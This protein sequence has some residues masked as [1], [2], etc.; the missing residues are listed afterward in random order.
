MSSWK[1]LGSLVLR[2]FFLLC[3]FYNLYLSHFNLGKMI[4]EKCSKFKKNT[5]LKK[6]S[7]GPENFWAQVIWTV[8]LFHR[9][10]AEG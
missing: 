6:R 5:F 8:L 7:E 4:S 9:E 10:R 1:S 2:V 3:L